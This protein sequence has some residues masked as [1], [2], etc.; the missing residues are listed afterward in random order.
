MNCAV[1]VSYFGYT[2]AGKKRESRCLGCKPRDKGCSFLKKDCGK[3]SNESVK[4]CF[5]CEDFPCENLKELD[6]GYRE[7]Y[8]MSMIENLEFIKKNGIEAF[9]EQQKEKFKCPECGSTICVHTRKC[10]NCKNP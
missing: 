4:Y 5:E 8:G 10:Y 7:K 3:L 9:L 2:M 1:C 6:E